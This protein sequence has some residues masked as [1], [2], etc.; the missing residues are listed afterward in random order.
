MRAACEKYVTAKAKTELHGR[1]Q[2]VAESVEIGSV[3][4]RAVSRGTVQA[5]ATRRDF[6]C[7]VERRH[8]RWEQVTVSFLAVP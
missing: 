6:Q 2:I 5:N 8:G 1:P 3:R 7:A 4:T